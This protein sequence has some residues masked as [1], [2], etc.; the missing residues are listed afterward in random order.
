L[1]TNTSLKIATRIQAIQ[2]I[3]HFIKEGCMGLI[4]GIFIQDMQFT[5]HLP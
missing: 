1:F 4:T 3:F 2:S 5:L